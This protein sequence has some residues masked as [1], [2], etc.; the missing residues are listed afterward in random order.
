MEKQ[1]AGRKELGDFAPNS[2][3][4]RLAKCMGSF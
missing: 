3:L 4:F 1:T 2:V